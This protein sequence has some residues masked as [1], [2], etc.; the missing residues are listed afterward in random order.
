M[1]IV[2]G[3]VISCFS[4]VFGLFCGYFGGGGAESY[5]KY[6]IKMA[7]IKAEEEQRIENYIKQT[8]DDKYEK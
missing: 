2:V 6:K 8:R 3:V 1:N 5:F 4:F 7:E